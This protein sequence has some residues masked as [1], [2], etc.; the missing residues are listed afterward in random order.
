VHCSRYNIDGIG[1]SG[2]LVWSSDQLVLLLVYNNSHRDTHYSNDDLMD[3]DII[4]V[5]ENMEDCNFVDME[6]ALDGSAESGVT[7]VVVDNS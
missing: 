4:D 5:E 6:A 7:A 3:E 2:R 1:E